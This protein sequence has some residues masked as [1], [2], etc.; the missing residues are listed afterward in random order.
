MFVCEKS[1]WVRQQKYQLAKET[2][3][4]GSQDEVMKGRLAQEYI[5]VILNW[6]LSVPFKEWSSRVTLDII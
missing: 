2:I 5:M 1:P 3:V 6:D 4:K